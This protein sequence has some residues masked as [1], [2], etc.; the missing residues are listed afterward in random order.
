MAKGKNLAT[1][2]LESHLV[3]GK[4]I[5]GEEITIR[6]DQT[7]TQDA[8]G[9]LAYI[10]FGSLGFN[11][12]KTEVSA[13]YVD[14]NILQTDFRNAD[15][16]LF[17]KTSAMRYGVHF[18]PPGNGVSHPVHMQMFG[19]PGKSLLGSDSHTCTAG[20]LG[21][22]A[23]GAGGLDVALAMAGE[24]FHMTCPKIMGV[25]LTGK[26]KPWVSAKDVILEMLRRHTVKGGVGKIIEY[27]GPGVKTL[28]ATERATIA[29]M[30]AELGAT[31]TVFPSDEKTKAFLKSQDRGADWAALSADASAEYDLMDEINLSELEPLVALPGSPDRVVKVTEAEGTPIQQVIIGSSVNFSYRDMAVVAKVLEE[32]MVHQDVSFEVNPGSR[33]VLEQLEKAGATLVLNHAGARIHESGCLGCIGNGQAPATGTNSLRTFP[34]NFKGRSG[35]ED[36]NV[37]LSSPEVAAAAA[38]YGKITDPR[39]LGKYPAIADPKL[40]LE[41]NSSVIKPLSA[42]ER[43]KVQIVRGPNIAPYPDFNPLPDS[44][45]GTVLLKAG[46]NVNT[47]QILP[48]G[49]RVLGF[50]SNIPKISEFAFSRIDPSFY[51]RAKS[52]GGGIVIGGENYGQGSS[53]E[54]AA[55]APRYLGVQIKV[56]KSFARIHRQNLVNLGIVPLTFQNP[57]DWEGLNPG[58]WMRF[59]NLKKAILDQSDEFIAYKGDWAIYLRMDFTK[60]ERDILIEGGLLN[61]IRRI[62]GQELAAD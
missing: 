7:L 12:V 26:L 57:G 46:D 58:D 41:L 13:S 25:K 33:Q 22:L 47:D 38:V 42:K 14:H 15:D 1:K 43:E 62:R 35:T 27:F 31:T 39:K 4:L 20:A 55:I 18:S 40:F 32:N 16:H 3:S 54:H 51:S 50:R 2:L 9:T 30:G 59:T 45:E 21:M 60:R 24:P 19:M 8:T 53:R 17:L 37:F 48:G 36:D 52:S 56:A 28:S 10:V 44:F 5:P 11:S 49:D 23:I 6:I 61:Y 34:R 29:N